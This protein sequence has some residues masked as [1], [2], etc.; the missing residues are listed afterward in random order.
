MQAL[1]KNHVKIIDQKISI[2]KILLHAAL[3][4]LPIYALINEERRVQFGHYNET[5]EDGTT[6]WTPNEDDYSFK[7]FS[8]VPIGYRSTLELL[9]VGSTDLSGCPLTEED[10]FGQVW[11]DSPGEND[12]PL[13]VT[14]AHVYVDINELEPLLTLNNE[15]E[16][17]E[18]TKNSQ[19]T[20]TVSSESNKYKSALKIIR[21]L[22]KK[23][24]IDLKQRGVARNI[25]TL[26]DETGLL[27][28]EETVLKHIREAANLED[29]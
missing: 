29:E 22:A 18:E 7:Y 1:T 14:L 24:E 27:I 8:I 17:T 3:E 15:S 9:R 6:A 21:A 19:K 20:Q 28:T 12:K 2:E 26:V 13:E 16:L 11:K 25:K 23:L 5:Y 10:R 4:N